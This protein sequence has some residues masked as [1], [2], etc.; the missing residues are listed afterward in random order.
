MTRAKRRLVLIGDWDTLCTVADHRKPA[1][2][3]ANTYGELR[4]YLEERNCLKEVS[5]SAH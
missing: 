1:E 2:S 5:I 4:N 3:C